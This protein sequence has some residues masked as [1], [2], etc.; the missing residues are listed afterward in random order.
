MRGDLWD[1]TAIR[2]KLDYWFIAVLRHP[3]T[4]SCSGSLGDMKELAVQTKGEQKD[5]WR[6]TECFWRP[7]VSRQKLQMPQQIKY[8][9]KVKIGYLGE[10]QSSLV[11]SSQLT[12]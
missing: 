11:S 5:F 2:V 8:D 1:V 3:S 9:K 10:P 7:Y 6:V 12:E 4:S